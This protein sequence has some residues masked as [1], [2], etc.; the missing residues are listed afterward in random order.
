MSARRRKVPPDDGQPLKDKTDQ[1]NQP[2]FIAQLNRL[3]EGIPPEAFRTAGELNCVTYVTVF[4]GE[5]THLYGRNGQTWDIGDGTLLYVGEGLPARATMHLKAR[6]KIPCGQAGKDFDAFIAAHWPNFEAYLAASNIT[7]AVA[8]AFEGVLLREFDPPFNDRG[9]ASTDWRHWSPGPDARALMRSA[10]KI[11]FRFGKEP[12]RETHDSRFWA[13]CF[14]VGDRKHWKEIPGDWII[15]RVS[16]RAKKL[17]GKP[18]HER[19]H[20]ESYPVLSRDSLV[21]QR[22]A[23]ALRV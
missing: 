3:A 10:E 23:A 13:N 5:G 12:P 22:N 9:P 18:P 16:N 20:F 2:D 7:K 4:R 8:V 6:A 17:D 11:D 21:G 14:W 1:M 19:I 15:T